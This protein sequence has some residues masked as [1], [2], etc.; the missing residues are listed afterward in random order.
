MRLQIFAARIHR[1]T[2]VQRNDF[3]AIGQ[4]Y[5]RETPGPAAAIEDHCAAQRLRRPFGDGVK[6]LPR[7]GGAVLGIQLQP[8]IL[9]PLQA[10]R[11]GVILPFN[12][13]RDRPDNGKFPLATGAGQFALFDLVAF[14][15][16]DGE[17]ESPPTLGAPEKVQKPSF[18][19][20]RGRRARSVIFIREREN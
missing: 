8:R 19:K 10:K 6:A 2:Q 4:R 5:L 11:V 15:T 16:G 3:R 17:V 12:K 1:R 7:E 9:V 20:G 14:L 13:A 18:H